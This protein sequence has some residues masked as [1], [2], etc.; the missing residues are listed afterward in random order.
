M[1]VC[2]DSRRLKLFQETL[3]ATRSA[4]TLVASGEESS[5]LT[6]AS[7]GPTSHPELLNEVVLAWEALALKNGHSGK[8]GR[9]GDGSDDIVAL[10]QEVRSAGCPIPSDLLSRL[11]YTLSRLRWPVWSQIP[12]KR[13]V[14][15]SS[16]P[17]VCCL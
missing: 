1:R 12:T 2:L 4:T 6:T 11:E 3:R 7:K 17:T 16:V 15:S 14:L 9:D 13:S 5:Q 8:P 10:R